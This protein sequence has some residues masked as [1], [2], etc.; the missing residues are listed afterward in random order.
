MNDV[1]FK[2]LKRGRRRFY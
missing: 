1:N 2:A